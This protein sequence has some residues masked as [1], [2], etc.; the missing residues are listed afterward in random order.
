MASHL[1]RH[2]VESKTSELKIVPVSWNVDVTKGPHLQL[3]LKM[4]QLKDLTWDFQWGE[5]RTTSPSSPTPVSIVDQPT[6]C[7]KV[8]VSLNE[9]QSLHHKELLPFSR[10]YCLDASLNRITTFKGVEALPNLVTLNL[11]HNSIKVVDGLEHS[12]HL[13]ELH[14][15]MNAI[16]DISNMPILYNLTI[17]RLNS[18]Q[19]TSLEGIQSL[20]RLKELHV[21]KNHLTDLFPLV[22]SLGLVV[23][24]AADNHL[25]SL[26][27]TVD[28]L[29]GLKRLHELYLM[30]NP[31]QKEN[32]YSAALTTS[33]SV[34]MLD[35]HSIS[36]A[37]AKP[38]VAQAIQPLLLPSG[39]RPQALADLKSAA[40]KIFYEQIE[41][42]KMRMDENVHYLQ[43]KIHDVQEEFRQYEAKT[44]AD[45]DS[46]LRYMD[47]LSLED[48][49]GAT[50]NMLRDM[51]ARPGPGPWTEPPKTGPDKAASRQSTRDKTKPKSQY[52]GVT[53]PDEVLKAAAELLS[54]S[55][56]ED[57]DS[58]NSDSLS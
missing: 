41:R 36:S 11:S 17:L 19:L 5:G 37:A 8:D 9:L 3:E 30:G 33:T 25:Q 1:S 45:L 2:L 39:D 53:E 27:D 13:Q 14:L 58:L 52:K 51:M 43:Q 31:L 42:Q 44:L 47:H 22:S 6:R 4:C 26:S 49:S 57:R 35:G 50:Q 48:M 29:K 40:R 24:N 16:T 38:T 10:L 18:N 34:V 15:E 20:S 54:K 12:Q 55:R 7:L 23:L 21:Q 56:Q 32:R 28:V 46:C